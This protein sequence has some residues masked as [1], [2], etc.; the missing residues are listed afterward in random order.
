MLAHGCAAARPGSVFKRL[1]LAEQ[2][3]LGL[4]RL[5]LLGPCQPRHAAVDKCSD[6]IDIH[7][8]MCVYARKYSFR[9]AVDFTSC[10]LP[11]SWEI[12]L[13]CP[14]PQCVEWK[15]GIDAGT[16]RPTIKK[17][18]VV[19]LCLFMAMQAQSAVRQ[20]PLEVWDTQAGCLR[21]T[22]CVAIAAQTSKLVFLLRAM[23]ITNEDTEH[24][25]KSLKELNLS[26]DVR[27]RA[28]MSSWS[29]EGHCG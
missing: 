6:T 25:D 26:T 27:T 23:G 2:A 16:T 8:T 18:P 21:E 17:Q 11:V 19:I 1:L 9:C 28:C 29:D 20:G 14:E 24:L 7:C 22:A 13:K 12:V 5:A 4:A 10:L 15:C 3:G